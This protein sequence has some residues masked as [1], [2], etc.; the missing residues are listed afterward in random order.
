MSDYENYLQGLAQQQQKTNL[1]ASTLGDAI[2]TS[3]D[4]FARMKELSK[5]ASMELS[6]VPQFRQTA[7]K[8]AYLQQVNI[9]KLWEDSPTTAR[10]L[11]DPS[12]AGMA[13]DDVENMG[14]VE[15][16]FRGTGDFL[17]GSVSSFVSGL[18]ARP[19]V[20]LYGLARAGAELLPD[21]IGDPVETWAAKSA[22]TASQTAER[23][24]PQTDNRY[25]RNWYSGVTSLGSNVAALINY[26]TTAGTVNPLVMMGAQEYGSSYHAAREKNLPVWQSNLYAGSNAAI[27]V[28]TERMSIGPMLKMF[29]PGTA[30]GKTVL[31][32]VLKEQGGEQIAT[33]FQDLN[34]WV[35]LNPNKSFGDY[36][37]ERPNAALDTAMSTLVSSGLQSGAAKGV[38]VALNHYDKRS[39]QSD[40]N[41]QFV[42]NINKAATASALA[43]R[44]PETFANF[45]QE[46]AD[47]NDKG[48]FYISAD[49]LMQSGVAEQA[50]ALSPAIAEQLETAVQTGDLIAIPAGEYVS[51]L[52]RSE[53]AQQLT[54]HVKVDADAWSKAEA[55][56]WMASEE[57]SAVQREMDRLLEDKAND[58]AFKASAKVVSDAV[59]QEMESATH[60]SPE[61]RDVNASLFSRGISVLAA[62]MGMMP[63]EAFNR[64]RMRAVNGSVQQGAALDYAQ[65]HRVAFPLDM[66][67]APVRDVES[68]MAYVKNAVSEAAYRKHEAKTLPVV[69]GA[70]KKKNRSVSAVGSIPLYVA[71]DGTLYVRKLGEDRILRATDDDINALIASHAEEIADTRQQ[72][73]SASHAM[74]ATAHDVAQYAHDQGATVRL[75]VPSDSNSRYVYIEHNGKSLKVRVA[76]HAQPSGWREDGTHGVVGGYDKAASVRHAASDISID[77]RSGKTVADAK[78]LVDKLLD[79]NALNQSA[80]NGPEVATTPL[81]QGVTEIEVDGTVRPSLNSNGK[82]IHWSEE[83]VRNFWRGFGD[84]KVV[85]AQGRPL[86]VY[87][88]TPSDF[89]SFSGKFLG[90]VTRATSSK[91]GFFF[92]STPRTAQ[93]YADHGATV[94]PVQELVEQAEKA[95]DRGNWD[96]YDELMLEA[97]QLEASMVGDGMARGQNI[98]PV[99]LSIKNPLEIDAAGESPEG[100]GGIDPLI[101]RAQREG[102]DGVI[103]R[104]FDDAAGL[105]NELAD[106][107]IAFR[108]EQIK[109]AI[110][111]NGQFNPQDANILHQDARGA[112]SLDS[113]T[114]AFLQNADETTFI[115]EAG[116]YFLELYVDMAL[117]L[118]VE[119]ANFGADILTTGEQGLLNDMNALFKWMGVESLGAWQAM[120]IEARRP[121]HE[122][123]AQGFEKYFLEGKAPTPELQGF[124][125]QMAAWMKNVYRDLLALNVELSDEVRGVFDRMLATTD[126]IGKAEQTRA[127]LPLFESQETSG[128]TPQEYAA[129]QD[130]A[131]QASQ[132]AMETLS[133]KWLKDMKWMRSARGKALRA[134][135]KDAL[136]VRA[137][138][139]DE[140]QREVMQRPVY[141]AWAFLTGKLSEQD[142]NALNPPKKGATNGLNERSDSLF[143]AIA[144]LGGIDRDAAKALWGID[145]RE[146][147]GMG[148]FG[149][150]VFRKGGGMSPDAMAEL[151]AQY[152]YLRID[153]NNSADM[154]D[155]E[156]KVWDELSGHPHKS[157]FYDYAAD[158]QKAGDHIANPDALTAGRLDA[159]ELTMLGLPD[160]WVEVL[161]KRGMTRKGGLHPDIVSDLFSDANGN[162]SF[163][164]GNELVRALVAAPDPNTTIEDE[165][166]RRMLAEH[167]EIASQQALDQAADA[168]VINDLRARVLAMEANALAKAVGGKKVMLDAATE[169][170]KQ[171]VGR[172]TIKSLKPYK[173]VNSAER[174]GRNAALSQKK[175]DITASAVQ[176]RQQVLQHELA[177]ISLAALDEVDR[178]RKRWSD[179]A[180]RG[181]KRLKSY[182]IDIVNVIRSIVGS[183]GIAPASAE[184]ASSYLDKIKQYDPELYA[185]I[186][187]IYRATTDNAKPYNELTVDEARELNDAL[188]GILYKAKRSREVEIG[189]KRV[190]LESVVIE[191]NDRMQ[192]IGV[193]ETMPG[194]AGAL[195]PSEIAG[196]KLQ[197]GWSMMRRVEQW[198]EG[199]D[200]KYGGPFLR[201]I[202]QPIKEAADRYRSDRVK[203]RKKYQAL[204]DQVAPYMPKGHIAAPELGYTFGLGHNGIGM[205]ELLHAVLHTGNDSNKRKLLLGR[206]WATLNQDGSID[207][208]QWDAFISR[209]QEEGTLTKAHYDFVQGA[210]DLLEETKPLAQRAH[211]EVFGRYF[212]EVTA[213]SFETPFGTYRGGYVPAQ[214]DPRLVQDAELRKL[215][216]L[217][218][219]GMSFAFPTTNKGFTHAR[220]EYNRK[221]IL[222]LRSIGQ[223]IDKVLLFSHM[224]PTV[225]DVHRILSDRTVS[226]NLGR[227][228]PTIYAGMLTPWLQRSAR[229]IVETPTTGDGGLSRI[230]SAARRRAGLAMMAA[231]ASNAIQQIT[232]FFSA[233]AKLK[234]DGLE[235]HMMRATAKFIANP[236]EVAR[237][238]AAASVFMDNR[239]ENEISAMNDAMNDIVLNP[240]LYRKTQAWTQRHAYFMQTAFANTMEPI[241]WT[242]GYNAAIQKGMSEA[243]AVSYADGL[244]RQTQGSTLPE[245]ISR[246]ESG[247]GWKRI[248]NQFAG[249]W[250]MMANTNATGLKQIAGD[251]GLKKGAGKAFM[252]VTQGLLIPIWVAEAIAV[253]MRGG[254]DDED[255]DGYLDDWL[256]QV[257]GFGTIRG[258]LAMVPGGQFVNAGINRFNNNP[259]DDRVSISP[260]VSMIDSGLGV[261]DL[262]Y[263][264]TK[265]PDTINKRKAVRD[266]AS[267]IS[268]TTG[269]PAYPMARPLGYWAGV[270]DG[271]ITPTGPVDAVRGAVTGTPSPE[272]R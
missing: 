45:A 151:L 49:A 90:K 190:S 238:V 76:D 168:A 68:A 148:V 217:E 234:Q 256:A 116:H 84:S 38:Q 201:T 264:A 97:E 112:F 20:G 21:V 113:N 249:Y 42:E 224:E 243:D 213:T 7:E 193:P 22:K 240:S 64:R 216:E 37:S 247:D 270:E 91:S 188:D 46:V 178:N 252:L 241:I 73:A 51:A 108:P 220:T 1:L 214:A 232:G 192:E 198:V 163:A 78:A 133:A 110:G 96:K 85:D 176:K 56:F 130:M 172:T 67:A 88:G 136:E 18:F 170:A 72:V 161:D 169:Y 25:L 177:R 230:A 89:D 98:I 167:S 257:F 54:E 36:L 155:L 261:A 263:R 86:V 225:R 191:L 237:N 258:V 122:K 239:M 75:V 171:A 185:V 183:Y 69:D 197:H 109:S 248:F 229:Q 132:A 61:Q 103:I 10:T 74:L 271:R 92:A 6:L 115:H 60:L 233:R 142:R 63:E 210:W 11:S 246:Y 127:L 251:V 221:L 131:L 31:E 29:K 93:S 244:I 26:Y 62:K 265:D 124:F 227:I 175:G 226:E 32:Y 255:D 13:H 79:A 134:L 126:E 23:W 125:R 87:H 135:Q 207:T 102:R 218:N 3:P 121:H 222:D 24:T 128:M 268:L 235:S 199:M 15:K 145:W 16:S 174:A 182:D 53:I 65:A 106:H 159:D 9:G 138:V 143:T 58:D 95:G 144:K 77:P 195:T 223:H 44:S 139:R 14:L 202:F 70:G 157:V 212:D 153:E 154:N 260:V 105:Y 140:V 152:G 119:A 141:R 228:D 266:V 208:G 118:Q 245:D 187:P 253:A 19:S 114:I 150:P 57:G 50:A 107:F 219:E 196:R 189:G 104:N 30:L 186:D 162:P 27:E 129:Y 204:V 33:H 99:Y 82:P 55:A 5:A 160:G 180:R 272:S 236:R 81:A 28:G 194:D 156:A 41:A 17:G 269:L 166:D 80:F 59:R 181:D 12:I 47:A 8:A 259:M 2:E 242:A 137:A 184:K 101:K 83:G 209:L 94:A 173:H 100:I 123:L 39:Q 231:N 203:Y 71:N 40:S 250:V 211:R 48:T 35:A 158:N 146:A 4:D 149:K 206:G 120:D 205:A 262:A 66:P 165:V 164:N 179:F 200:G 267:L 43:A 215:A 147:K 254:P 117:Q 52:A 111:N 34:E